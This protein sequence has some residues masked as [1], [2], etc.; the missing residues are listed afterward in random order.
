MP[1][2]MS[3]TD[4]GRMLLGAV[5]LSGLGWLS[6]C[7]RISPTEP[8]TGAAAA[9]FG[10]PMLAV[11]PGQYVNFFFHSHQDDWQ[12]FMGD[13][14]FHGLEST[15]NVVFVYTTAG[16]GG[17]S[18]TY[19][20]TRELAAQAAMDAILPAGS[21][22]CAGQVV[23]GHTLRRCAKGAAV[24]YD[25][26]LPD[27]G[28]GTGFQG[29]GSL[30]QLRDG[31]QPTITAVDGSTTYTSWDDFTATIRGIVDLEGA[32]QGAPFVSVNAPD[33][34]RTL[35]RGDHSDH[36]ATADA[37]QAAASARSWNLTWYIDYWTQNLAAN[38][39]TADRNTKVQSFY[40]YD[41]Y[42][43]SRGYGYERYDTQYQAWLSATYFRTEQSVPVP[44]PNAPTGLAASATSASRIALTWTDNAT[45]ETGFRVERAP[46]NGGV[47]GAFAV[48]ATLGTDAASF[49]DSGLASS[50]AYWYRVSAYNGTDQSGYSNVA[51]SAT[52]LMPAS[53]SGLQGAGIS[54]TRIDLTWTDNATNETAYLV[55]RA[56][57]NAGVAG[58]YAQVAALAAGSTSYSNTG[59]SANTP[60]WYRVR[61][62]DATDSSAYSPAITVSTTVGPPAPSNLVATA[63]SA[64]QIDL[65]WVDNTTTESGF[66]VERAPNVS[67]APGTFA[68]IA[69][70]APNVTTYSNTGLTANTRYWYRVRAFDANDVSAYSNTANATT[71]ALPP[72][73]PTALQATAMSATRIDLGWTDHANN[74]TGFRIERAPDNAGVAGTYAEIATVGANVTTYSNTG[75]TANTRYWYRVRAYNSVGTSAYTTAA[76]ATTLA[77]PAIR[78]D[79]YLHAHQD[80]WQLFMGDRAYN[81]VQDASNVVFVYATAGDGG[82]G[83]TYWQTRELA[84]QA[85]V[86]ALIGSGAWTCAQQ[87]INAHPIR[88]C[89]KGKAVSYDLRLPDGGNGT[90]F[91][92]AG[93]MAMLRDGTQP[94]LTAL[95]GSTTYTSW[96]D[97]TTTIQGII[98]YEASTQSV[99]L[100]N[101]NAPDYDRTINRGD[102]ADHLAVA[103][104]VLAASGGRSWGL[105]WYIDYWTQNLAANLTAAQ[106]NTK[107]LSFYA[108]DSYMG[109]R[110]YGYERYDTQY[111]AWLGRTYVR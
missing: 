105:S 79:V 100:V 111:Q 57:D 22:S 76:S 71:P 63:T 106:K 75:L 29:R 85:A 26:R 27:G 20:Q 52:F 3:K 70:L 65:T 91:N 1:N 90:G 61:A 55:E 41:G 68:V 62:V 47:P 15:P 86:D 64:T 73:A 88:R 82:A 108:Y 78:T 51:G 9:N 104:A 95:D 37:V 96:T 28:N 43:G 81:S 32:G 40:A 19:W 23:N 49:T 89:A 58:T 92:G 14:A 59:L 98:D 12:L 93:S 60:Y 67:G 18:D 34:D 80:D 50:A 101:V 107:T 69:T 110:G 45:N 42:M 103:D 24:A 77:G 2:A 48:I 38:L 30:A 16:D 10:R 11:A 7:E 13:H 36:L 17:A 99:P 56:P 4:A 44:P 39:S 83:T 6:G 8:Q 97:F 33:Y 66:T 25:M 53:P 31:V 94:T 21:W 72:A 102:H 84:A 87:T 5:L 46:D 35:N 109:T 74:E 54:T